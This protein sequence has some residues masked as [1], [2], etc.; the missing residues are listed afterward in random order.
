MCCC[1]SVSRGESGVVNVPSV[2]QTLT[3]RCVVVR[4]KGS[5]NGFL[6][7]RVRRTCVILATCLVWRQPQQSVTYITSD[8]HYC[9]IVCTY[10]RN[11]RKFNRM[12]SEPPSSR[13][14]YNKIHFRAHQL[15]LSVMYER[16]PILANVLI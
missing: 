4:Q 13:E 14:E 8:V 16:V 3:A 1:G 7:I 10:V 15:Q 6:M 11:T 9:T 2:D 5:S 12:R